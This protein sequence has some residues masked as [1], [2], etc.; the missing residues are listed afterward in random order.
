[1]NKTKILAGILIVETRLSLR[2]KRRLLNYVENANEFEVLSFILDSKIY[3]SINE[4]YKQDLLKRKESINEQ[5][6]SKAFGLAKHFFSN[7]STLA[8]QTNSMMY[9]AQSISQVGKLI[10]PMLSQ[11]E[12]ACQGRQGNDKKACKLKF[13]TKALTQEINMLNRVKGY[14][15]ET[16]GDPVK[17]AQKI[18]IKIA[19]IKNKMGAIQSQM[20]TLQS[21]L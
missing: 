12:A 11:A 3:P 1:M 9:A 18:D 21:E 14:C 7:A 8:T 10:M 4:E 2:M 5:V 19:K 20:S 6:L 15:R 13:K 17:C 16:K